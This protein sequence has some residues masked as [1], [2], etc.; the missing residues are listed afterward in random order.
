MA[1]H[2]VIVAVRR[3]I[4]VVLCIATQR[5]EFVDVLHVDE[6]PGGR[7]IALLDFLHHLFVVCFVINIDGL[8]CTLAAQAMRI[9]YTVEKKY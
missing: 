7:G 2:L 9:V 8:A 4:V 3:L 1:T 6:D 5:G